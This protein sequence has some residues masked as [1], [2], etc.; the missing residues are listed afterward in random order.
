MCGYPG[1]PVIYSFM[2]RNVSWEVYYDDNEIR[3]GSNGM[4]LVCN[5]CGG[6]GDKP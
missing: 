6:I 2:E 4:T 3:N 1:L 5:T